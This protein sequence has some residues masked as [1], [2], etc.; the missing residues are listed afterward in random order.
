MPPRGRTVVVH[1]H[2][3]VSRGPARPVHTAETAGA[4]I[5]GVLR[6]V[7]GARRTAPPGAHVQ[8]VVTRPPPTVVVSRPAP[9]VTVVT[10]PAPV[11][12]TVVVHKPAP[13]VQTV[14]VDHKSAAP[15]AAGPVT[16]PT[17]VGCIESAQR[18]KSADVGGK[19]DPYAVA[20]VYARNKMTDSAPVVFASYTTRTID[21]NLNPVWDQP[22]ILRFPE[23]NMEFNGIQI[24]VW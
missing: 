16:A 11:V 10:R 2:V 1:K 23:N 6:G 13:V 19:S 3:V 4:L 14:I 24:E 8:V 17:I 22:F 15:V 21:G 7:V 12:R 9:V 18:L 5:G 20:R